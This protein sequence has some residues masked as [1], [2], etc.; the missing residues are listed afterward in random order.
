ML[1]LGESFFVRFNLDLIFKIIRNF[2]ILPKKT[3][4]KKNNIKFG[5]LACDKS[6]G[7]KY[8]SK[9]VKLD[10]KKKGTN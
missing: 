10:P 9:S 7:P 5:F 4:N 8:C 2:N 1:G 3:V 6:F